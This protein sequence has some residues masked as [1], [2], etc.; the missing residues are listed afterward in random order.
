MTIINYLLEVLNKINL[1][2]RALNFKRSQISM[3]ASGFEVSTFLH[4]EA[5]TLNYCVISNS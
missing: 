1:I 4:E 5:V 2:T 3:R